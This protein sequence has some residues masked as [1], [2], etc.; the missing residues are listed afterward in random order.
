M[1]STLADP[2]SDFQLH[3]P[4]VQKL[5][6]GLTLV[7]E[8]IPVEAVNLSVWLGIGSSVEAESVNGVAHF[9]EHMIFKGTPQIH[10]GEFERA[11]EARGAVTNAATSQDYTHYYVTAA[12]PDFAALAP[13][14]IE[15]LLNASLEET[16]F[17][18]ERPVILE[19]IRQSEDNLRRRNFY[20]FM[21]LA[22]DYLPY[23]RQVLGPAAVVETVTPAQMREFHA[24]WY[25]PENLTI[26]AVGT[27][28][29]E[30]A[31]SV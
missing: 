24:R 9:L 18:R 30:V 19:E 8:Q 6:N 15:L 25:R 3:S 1:H 4:T 7:V 28:L 12:P 10:C 31:T 14:Q 22:F 26:V 27:S 13:L 5:S 21:E 17:E 20:R 29:P 16:A 23:R 11:L 2:A